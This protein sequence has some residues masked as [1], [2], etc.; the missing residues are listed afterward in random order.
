MLIADILES[1]GTDVVTIAPTASV[2][3]LVACLAEHRV[4][5]VVVSADGTTIDGIV[6]ER[7]IVRALEDERV[8]LLAAPVAHIMTAGVYTCTRSD[9]VVDL[10]DLMTEHRFRHVPVVENGALAGLVS[11]GDVVKARTALLE[12]ER[13][14]LA[15]G[16]A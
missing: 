15:R 4:G 9:T 1:K 2:G 8:A 6:S 3:D 10:A 11:I 12:E 13:D 16:D 5:A 14:R 7:D